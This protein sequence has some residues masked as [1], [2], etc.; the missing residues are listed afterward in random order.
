MRSRDHKRLSSPWHN[1]FVEVAE[2]RKSDVMEELGQRPAVGKVQLGARGGERQALPLKATRTVETSQW[3]CIS[4]I[5][6]VV[7]KS[8]GGS[9]A[10]GFA[11]AINLG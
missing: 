8:H 7:I 4:G 2:I 6:F 3:R 11:D 1:E 5:E 10:E 9:D